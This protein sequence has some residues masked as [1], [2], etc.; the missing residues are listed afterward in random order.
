ML[1]GWGMTSM[2]RWIGT[3]MERLDYDDED[4]NCRNRRCLA[5]ENTVLIEAKDREIAYRKLIALGKFGKL[6]KNDVSDWSNS[7]TGRKGRWV[8]DGVTSLLPIYDELEDG[9]ELFFDK[10]D[11]KSVKTIQSKIRQKKD[12]EAFDDRELE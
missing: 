10:H 8:F 3:F 9:A 11:G 7:D 2:K 1:A 12:L 6:G 4:S 5:W